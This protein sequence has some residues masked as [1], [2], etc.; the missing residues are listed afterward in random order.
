MESNKDKSNKIEDD[1]YMAMSKA[2]DKTFNKV[3]N[4]FVDILTCL[5]L[6]VILFVIFIAFKYCWEM[7][8]VIFD[9]GESIID[10]FFK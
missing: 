5:L 7:L 6:I 2:F 1:E 9:F 8:D 4:K 3:A 10:S